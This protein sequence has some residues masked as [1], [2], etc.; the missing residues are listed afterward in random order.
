MK[1]SNK[2]TVLRNKTRVIS[3]KVF[4]QIHDTVPAR[5]VP[6]FRGPKGKKATV[7]ISWHKDGE[8]GAS[9][10]DQNFQRLLRWAVQVGAKD[11]PDAII[12]SAQALQIVGLLGD[13][14]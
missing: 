7:A 4:Y 9:A 10:N 12:D 6:D 13:N 5:L 11:L 2:R 14:N 3:N 8:T 1:S